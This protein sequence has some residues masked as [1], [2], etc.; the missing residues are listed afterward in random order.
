ML[1]V[2]PDATVKIVVSAKRARTYTVRPLHERFWAMVEPEPN[3]GCWIWIGASWCGYGLIRENGKFG[4]LLK[5]HRVSW[6]LH[7]GP[8]ADELDVLHSCDFP[9]CVCPAHLR[10]GTQAENSQEAAAK[11]RL[12]FQ[13]HPEKCPRGEQ[14]ANAKLTAA[15]VAEIR[16]LRAK[17]W[18]QTRIAIKFG[19]TQA[20]ISYLLLGKTWLDRGQVRAGE[21]LF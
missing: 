12:V 19:V 6:A 20:N 4:R 8:L 9:S 10:T 2:S 5:A 3:S 7:N 13:V 18:T 1:V 21:H 14:N 15:Q 16:I 11:G 17:G